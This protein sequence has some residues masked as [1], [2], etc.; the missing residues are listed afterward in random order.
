MA[1]Q[2]YRRHA[3]AGPILDFGAASGELYHMLETDGSYS[4]I[5]SNSVLARNLIE[6]A[7]RATREDLTSLPEDTYAAVFALDALEHNEDVG[8]LLDRLVNGLSLSGVMIISGP[9]ENALYRLGRRISGFGGGYHKTTIAA[10]ECLADAQLDLVERRLVPF[11][12]PLFSIS[13]WRRVVTTPAAG[14]RRDSARS[15]YRN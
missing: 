7:P 1:A 10:I 6:M 11:G 3:P 5:E 9:T 4:F 8:P 12:I 14:A 2:L 13:V 15:E